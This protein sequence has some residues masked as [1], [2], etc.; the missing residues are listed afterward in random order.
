MKELK[1]KFYLQKMTKIKKLT[2]FF[3][4]F[5][6]TSCSFDTKTGVWSNLEEEERRI[7]R[8]EDDQ[9]NDLV[10][11]YSSEKK[12]LKEL[13]PTKIISLNKPLNNN[14]WSMTGLNL[15][16]YLGNLYLKSIDNRF[17]KKRVGKNKFK[18]K[19]YFSPPLVYENTIILS[20]DTGTI[21]SVN[22]SG[23]IQWKKNIY[24]KLYKKIN[25]KLSLAIYKGEIYISD[26]IGFIYSLNYETGEIIWLKNLEVPLKSNIK[27]SNDKIYVIN[28]ENRILCLDTKTGVKIWDYRSVASFIKLPNLLSTAVTKNNILV[29]LTSSGDLLKLNSENGRVYWA[30]SAIASNFAHDNDF[31]SS[32]EIVVDQNSVIFSAASTFYSF[33]L[34][35]GYLNWEANISS[36]NIPI[37]DGE[38]IFTVTENGFFV[39]IEKNS[40]KIVWVVNIF[41][42]LKERKQNTKVTG[43]V[44]GSGK[45]YA[46][47]ENGYLISASASTG[48]IL[49]SKKIGENIIADPIISN[50]SL[51]ILT[52][53]SRILGFN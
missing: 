26:N 23:K 11:I 49:N 18:N 25:K 28:Q 37:V 17:L 50:G 7:A 47:T 14:I 53:K 27:V 42:I 38:N 39:N 52:E 46:A 45:I 16:N 31:F 24:K 44:M 6:F 2:F 40:G 35:N 15:Q 3:L 19:S 41:K 33:N 12:R 22:Q 30:L 34:S 51:Y 9:N 43:I 13:A 20:D 36:S 32:S 29:A 10:T 1:Y 4:L 5:L 21:F 48:E 8:L